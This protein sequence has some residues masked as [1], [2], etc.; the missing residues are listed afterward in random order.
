M[1]KRHILK[2]KREAGHLGSVYGYSWCSFGGNYPERNEWIKLQLFSKKFGPT[3]CVR[4]VSTVGFRGKLQMLDFPPCHTLFQFNDGDY[5]IASF[6]SDWR[7]LFWACLSTSVRNVFLPTA[8]NH[9]TR[10]RA[11]FVYTLG[12][13]HIYKNET[14]LSRWFYPSPQT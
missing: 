3:G 7:M 5:C 6:I 14:L 9:V 4:I 2:F 11:E 1:R 12:D 10:S 8:Y 13:Y